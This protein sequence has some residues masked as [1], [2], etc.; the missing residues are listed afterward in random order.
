MRGKEKVGP[1]IDINKTIMEGL[2]D[3]AKLQKKDQNSPTTGASPSP[4]NAV[5]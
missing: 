4:I 1:L 3:Q 5:L 2:A